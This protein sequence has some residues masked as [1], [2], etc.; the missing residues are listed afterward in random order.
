MMCG[1]TAVQI[2]TAN[3]IDPGVTMK[4]IDGINTWCDEHGVKDVT[5]SSARSDKTPVSLGRSTHIN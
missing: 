4:V 1:A 3:F 2:G 5:K